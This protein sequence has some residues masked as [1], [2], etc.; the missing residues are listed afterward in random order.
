MVYHITP[1]IFPPYTRAM[2]PGGENF[3]GGIVFGVTKV[4]PG[5]RVVLQSTLPYYLDRCMRRTAYRILCTLIA[6]CALAPPTLFCCG[7]RKVRLRH[8]TYLTS[9]RFRIVNFQLASQNPPYPW[10]NLICKLTENANCEHEAS[11]C[12]RL[13][14]LLPHDRLG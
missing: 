14:S 1:K 10:R 5:P 6:W 8:Y 11:S 4:P 13:N 7:I 2:V 9:A 3:W 12:R